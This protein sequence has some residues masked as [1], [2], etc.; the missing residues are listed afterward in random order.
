V[1]LSSGRSNGIESLDIAVSAVTASGVAANTDNDNAPETLPSQQSQRRVSIENTPSAVSN[2]NESAPSHPAITVSTKRQ[3]TNNASRRVTQ[4]QTNDVP[5]QKH[6]KSSASSKATDSTLTANRKALVHN[7]FIHFARAKLL[8]PPKVPKRD[9]D[10]YLSEI[11]AFEDSFRIQCRH[12]FSYSRQTDQ[13]F[14]ES[15]GLGTRS[16]DTRSVDLF[17][18]EAIEVRTSDRRRLNRYHMEDSLILVV[19]QKVWLCFSKSAVSDPKG[20]WNK[21]KNCPLQA[22][23]DLQRSE[24]FLIIG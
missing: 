24:S 23:I 18:E 7:S 16:A 22:V 5:K 13:E 1:S 17:D 20:W 15:I 11:N 3:K 14:N 8:V 12:K 10:Q 4:T 21:N 2:R 9:T 6:K 19:G